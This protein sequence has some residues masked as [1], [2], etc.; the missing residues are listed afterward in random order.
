MGIFNVLIFCIGLFTLLILVHFWTDKTKLGNYLMNWFG[1]RFLNICPYPEADKSR[2]KQE[3]IY[4]YEVSGY[5]LYCKLGRETTTYSFS[6]EREAARFIRMYKRMYRG[7][8][9]R[10][11]KIMKAK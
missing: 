5:R 3:P 1:K 4:D 6:T 10:L 8:I 11:E 7:K 2:E 9:V